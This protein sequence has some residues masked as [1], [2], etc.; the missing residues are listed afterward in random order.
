LK[1][2]NQRKDKKKDKTGFNCFFTRIFILPGSSETTDSS[3][4]S[5]SPAPGMGRGVWIIPLVVVSTLT[6]LC[7]VMLLVVL[8]YWR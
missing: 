2:R 7:L 8:V 5:R 1:T 4:Q 3:N 6:L